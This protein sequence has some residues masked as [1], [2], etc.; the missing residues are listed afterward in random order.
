MKLHQQLTPNVNTIRA[1]ERD[2][3]RINNKSYSN[4][5]IVTADI[6][7][8]NWPIEHPEHISVETIIQLLAFQP[9]V[10]LIG[11]GQNHHLLN[12]M[13]SLE[14]TQQGIGIEIMT[15]EAACRTYNVLLG[16]DRAVLAALI[17]EKSPES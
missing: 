5:L 13:L 3:I 14:A 16:E 6:I 9:E 12:P 2:S 11:T 8:D 4:S 1:F 15:T 10:I 7:Q 17:I